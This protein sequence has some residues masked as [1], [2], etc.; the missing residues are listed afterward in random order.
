MR[1]EDFCKGGKAF[2]GA[3]EM[4]EGGETYRG[5]LVDVVDYTV[6]GVV[7]GEEVPAI[8]ERVSLLQ[9]G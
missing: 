4:E 5:S 9:G 8:E 6:R 3:R 7:A 1:F 2:A